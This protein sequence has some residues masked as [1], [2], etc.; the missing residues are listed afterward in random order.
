MRL[1]K[2]QH[3]AGWTLGSSICAM[4]VHDRVK[5][6]KIIMKVWTAQAQSESEFSS[7]VFLV[8]RKISQSSVF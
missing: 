2:T 8:K 3:H 7:E 1:S 6:Q 5:E 4:Y